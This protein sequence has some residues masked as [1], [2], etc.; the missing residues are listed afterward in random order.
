MKGIDFINMRPLNNEKI[1]LPEKGDFKVQV[2]A[3]ADKV[4]AMYFHRKDTISYSSAF[5]IEIPTGSYSLTWM[6]TKTG[7]KKIVIMKNHPGGWASISSP[8]YSEDIAL[9]LANN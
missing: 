4:Y 7:I 8:V 6:D 9:K 3:K 1:K 5:E 2:L